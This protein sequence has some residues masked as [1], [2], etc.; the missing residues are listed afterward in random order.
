M[1]AITV[2]FYSLNFMSFTIKFTKLR[3]IISSK[4]SNFTTVLTAGSKFYAC[5]AAVDACGSSKV[6][7]IDR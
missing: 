2:I 4:S 7:D 6:A 3:A 5:R 1:H